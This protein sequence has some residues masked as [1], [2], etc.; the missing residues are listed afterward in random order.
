MKRILFLVMAL[1]NGLSMH[2]MHNASLATGTAYSLVSAN[3]RSIELA[4]KICIGSAL[5]VSY[6]EIIDM[7][8]QDPITGRTFAD[9]EQ[10]KH[11]AGCEYVMARIVTKEGVVYCDADAWHKKMAL[12]PPL[13]PL[14]ELQLEGRPI[15]QLDYYLNDNQDKCMGRPTFY[16]NLRRVPGMLYYLGIGVDRDRRKELIWHQKVVKG[17]IHTDEDKEYCCLA[18]A[19]MSLIFYEHRL[20]H[21]ALREMQRAQVL[22]VDPETLVFIDKNIAR[23]KKRMQK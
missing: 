6:A 3:T 16:Q 15:L 2:A 9:L 4:K 5:S 23:I 14:S 17:A 1:N 10:E 21:D 20:F 19:Y 22:T 8:S 11:A 13:P 7:E 12:C 18:H